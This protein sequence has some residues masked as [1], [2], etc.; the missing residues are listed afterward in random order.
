MFDSSDEYVDK[1]KSEENTNEPAPQ[2]SR[3]LEIVVYILVTI[4]LGAIGIILWLGKVITMNKLVKYASLLTLICVIFALVFGWNLYTKEIILDEK[5]VTVHVRPNDTFG[6]VI[7][8]FDNANLL[9]NSFLFKLI[10]S[11]RGI[12][13]RLAVGR[14]DFSGDISL[15]SILDDLASG[16]VATILVTIPE[17][18]SIAQTASIFFKEMQIDS[19]E[20]AALCY[21]TTGVTNKYKLPDLEGY[22]FPETYR[23]PVESDA[24]FVIDHLVKMALSQVET[25]REEKTLTLNLRELVTMASIIEAEARDGDEREIISS[26]YHNRLKRNML[27]QADPTVRFALNGIRRRLFY[28]DLEV[29]SRYNTYKFKGL[30][31]GP[32]NSPGLASLAAAARPAQTDYLYFVA[33]GSGQ[34]VFSENLSG[35]NRARDKIKMEKSRS[36]TD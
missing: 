15:R 24:E 4:G 11:L 14:Y 26:V 27:M 3:L 5:I 18:L 17:G 32:I 20:F 1:D 6:E 7:S 10:A 12:D 21:D 13:R 33:A 36:K 31:P 9:S 8:Q 35:H 34:H 29:D 19:S 16:K 2:V 28:K 30:P 22:L 25:L 23:F